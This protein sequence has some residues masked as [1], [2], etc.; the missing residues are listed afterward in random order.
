MSA[1]SEGGRQSHETG[2]PGAGNARTAS[3]AAMVVR[4]LSPRLDDVAQTDLMGEGDEA[5]QI[6]VSFTP[7]SAGSTAGLAAT[8][9]KRAD[10]QS[11][12]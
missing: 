8:T 2:C 7:R 12:L 9:A 6:V 11:R 4:G 3:M 5:L 1:I 10:A